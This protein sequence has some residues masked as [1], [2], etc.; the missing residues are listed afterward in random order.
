MFVSNNCTDE[1]RPSYLC[2]LSRRW[3]TQVG[4]VWFYSYEALGIFFLYPPID[5]HAQHPAFLMDLGTLLEGTESVD[6]KE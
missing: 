5:S 6:S 4:W 3:A 1:H 2:H